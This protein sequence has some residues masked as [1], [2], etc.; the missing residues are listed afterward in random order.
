MYFSTL[1]TSV[2]VRLGVAS[3]SCFQTPAQRLTSLPFKHKKLFSTF[4][5]FGYIKRENREMKIYFLHWLRTGSLIQCCKSEFCLLWASVSSFYAI[6]APGVQFQIWT[7]LRK[8]DSEFSNG[9][10]KGREL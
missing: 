4:V 6:P 10:S 3:V 1:C 9:F 8:D 7:L 2:H 5:I